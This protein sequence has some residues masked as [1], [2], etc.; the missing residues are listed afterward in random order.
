MD[1]SETLI[2]DRHQLLRLKKNINER[3][4]NKLAT[5]KLERQFQE[6]FNKSKEEYQ[7]RASNI[8]KP[9]YQAAIANNLPIYQEKKRILQ[10]L[11]DNQVVVISADTGSG[12][13]T[14]LPQFLLELG[15]GARGIIAHTQPR[16]IAARTVAARIAEELQVELG[17]TV[18]YQVRFEENFS[19]NTAIKLMTDG[20]L[21]A[22]ILSDPY[23]SQYEVIIIDEAHE[24]SLNIDFLLGYLHKIRARRPDL[25]III[26]SATIDADK[27]AK[28]FDAVHISVAGKTFPVEIRY[29]PPST[30]DEENALL[31]AVL[32]LDSEDHFGDILIFLPTERDIRETAEILRKAE[33]KREI[34]PLFGR[35]SLAAQ[36]AVF[37]PKS[38]PRIVLATNVAE[39]SITV[40]RIKF[41][42][43]TGTARIS[44]YSAKSK[45]QRLPIEPIS[46][47]QAN[48]R[49][50]RCGRLSAGVCIRL[51]SQEDFL[52][53]PDFTEAEILRTNLAAVILKMLV[54]K[55]GDIAD[56]PFIDKPETRQIND[57]YRL[58]YE[59]KAVDKDNRLTQDGRK[60]SQ[61]PLDPRYCRILL[62]GEKLGVLQEVLIICAALSLQDPRERPFGQEQQ[63]TQKHLEFADQ[64]SDFQTFL[65]LF[66]Q[67][68]RVRR[69]F[70]GNK[71]T[72][73]CR[74]YFLNPARMREWSELVNQLLRELRAMKFRI[75]EFL[76]APNQIT[77]NSEIA[78]GS[79]GSLGFINPN[80][81]QIHRALFGGFLDNAGLWDEKNREYLGTR[82]RKFSIFPASTI[83]KKRPQ[84]IIAA[85][86]IETSK[87]YAHS[88]TQIELSELENAASH[89]TKSNFSNPHWSK[90]Q[91]AVVCEETVLLYGLPLV[92]GRKRQFGTINPELAREIFIREALLTGEI[93]TRL[94]V[95]QENLAL[96]RKLENIEE[97]TRTRGILCDEERIFEFY[98]QRLPE[99]I[100][101]V[102]NLEK[103]GKNPENAERI[104]LREEDLSE[105][106]NSKAAQFPEFIHIKK[107]K[108]HLQ[109]SFNPGAEDD[110]ITVLLP[111]AALNSVSAGD[112]EFLIPALLPEKIA[113][114][115]RSLPKLFRRQL[116]PIP[117]FA[118]AIAERILDSKNNEPLTEQISS[119]IKDMKGLNIPAS[120]F[121]EDK[122][123][124]HLK[125]NF[126]LTDKG[127]TLA[128]SRDLAALQAKFGE[129]AREKFTQNL[130]ES[131]D[132]WQEMEIS[133]WLWEELP[134][135][136]KIRQTLAYPAISAEGDKIYLRIIENC[137]KAQAIHQNGLVALLNKKLADKV[138]F[139]QKNLPQAQTSALF[140]RKFSA[141][142][143]YQNELI[144]AVIKAILT[145]NFSDIR[146]RN[147]LQ[148]ALEIANTEL[149]TRCNK[150]AEVLAKILSLASNIE[151]N[152]RKMT[153]NASHNDLQ[154]QFQELIYPNFIARTDIHKFGD[155]ERYL[156]GI[157]LRIK[158][159]QLDPFKE[160]KRLL[161]IN[162]ILQIFDKK[163]PELKTTVKE[164]IAFLIQEYRL[165]IFAQ[166][167]GARVKVSENILMK[168]FE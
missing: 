43:D 112:F 70:S 91:G 76:P 132:T 23:L 113:A 127:K 39:T 60:M 161:E 1:L 26:T 54:L 86:I 90:K 81:T 118:L 29:R 95:I 153:K 126:R 17:S 37:H 122:I 134:K 75:N 57:G 71:T 135:S 150:T 166:E 137:E 142:S 13:T 105:E 11:S 156:R 67:Y 84:A 36:Q 62:D 109:Y 152:L 59:L 110:G 8:P 117:E 42:I 3:R 123:E 168:Y 93:N 9:L 58:L 163:S 20:I 6:L 15:F 119:A 45:T 4:K 96:I 77:E 73:W 103:W 158:K 74:K 129:K 143:N 141:S 162:K 148:K 33:I 85:S 83:A 41:V 25:K 108:F 89:L 14:Q 79:R 48:Q 106:K 32:E 52:S 97:K 125:F 63:A 115:M 66:V 53:R 98:E 140:Y 149:I 99:N 114:L 7:H 124:A 22:E 2:K 154:R 19:E 116:V 10:A 111:L 121:Y 35:L 61:M 138:K 165:Q 157:E 31:S 51:Y 151:N 24:R 120:E 92:A 88:C 78:A 160:A 65:N 68:R 69:E 30:D 44:R 38:E 139:L 56:F 87:T 101:S 102:V 100:Y 164:E 159:I 46:K 130:E 72:N 55:L 27:F 94:K 34:L 16:R 136:I 128:E 21:L 50:G 146:K 145:E 131:A 49:A 167:I 12:K 5:S 147:D 133:D 47:A 80:I 155:I 82:N 40:P 144:A 104:K 28:H 107:Q 18:G 64:T